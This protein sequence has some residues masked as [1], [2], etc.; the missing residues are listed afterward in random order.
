MNTRYRSFDKN[1]VPLPQSRVFL[2]SAVSLCGSLERRETRLESRSETL[3]EERGRDRARE[4][5]WPITSIV[6][7]NIVVG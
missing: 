2:R 7:K 3:R 6:G 1:S 5:T 4:R